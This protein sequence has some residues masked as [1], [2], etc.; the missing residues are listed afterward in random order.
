MNSSERSSE[1]ERPA[2][3]FL[4]GL[5]CLRLACLNFVNRRSFD[6]VYLSCGSARRYPHTVLELIPGC[7]PIVPIPFDRMER[8]RKKSYCS[9]MRPVLEDLAYDASLAASLTTV[10]LIISLAF[11]TVDAPSL[12]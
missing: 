4:E 8:D 5:G 6:L 10:Y 2:L 11:I 12:E 7:F 9:D 3:W 1:E